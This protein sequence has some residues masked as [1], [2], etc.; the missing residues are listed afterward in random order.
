MQQQINLVDNLIQNMCN[1]TNEQI[2]KARLVSEKVSAMTDDAKAA[3]SGS[4]DNMEVG[5]SLID[6]VKSLK[7]WIH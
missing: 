1:V 5:H 2:E 7:A 3:V 4:H 6:S